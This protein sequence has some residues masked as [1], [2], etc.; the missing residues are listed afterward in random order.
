MLSSRRPVS[1]AAQPLG[2]APRALEHSIF[3]LAGGSC[4]CEV[5]ERCGGC[6]CLEHPELCC[7]SLARHETSG[8]NGRALLA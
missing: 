4:P 8:P 6:R 5:A 1:A 2:G 3:P 7:P